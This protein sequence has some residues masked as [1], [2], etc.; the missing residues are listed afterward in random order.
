MHADRTNRTLLIVLALLLL[1]VGLD[2]GAAP[3]ACTA[4]PPR[5]ARSW[6]IRPGLL[7][8]ARCLAVARRRGGRA[9]IGVLALRWLIAL[10]F[11]TDRSGD[12]LIRRAPRGRTTLANGA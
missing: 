5:T 8:R 12:L 7:R 9:D 11:S 1:A 6:T 2:A 4:P 10:L 3:S